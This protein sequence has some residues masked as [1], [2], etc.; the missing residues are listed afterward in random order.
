MNSREFRGERKELEGLYV[1]KPEGIKERGNDII[2][3][4]IF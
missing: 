1:R 3:V 2:L 4:K